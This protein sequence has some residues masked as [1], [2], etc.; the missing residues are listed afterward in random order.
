MVR[1]TWPELVGREVRYRDHTWE[2]TGP[3]DVRGTGER[4]AVEARQVDGVGHDT[5]T[6]RFGLADPP[7]SLNPGDLGEHFDRLERE[8][9]RYRLVV[10]KDARRYRYELRGLERS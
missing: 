1:T 9:D 3:V 8:G 10:E 2:L 4:L 7:D 5:A 6:L